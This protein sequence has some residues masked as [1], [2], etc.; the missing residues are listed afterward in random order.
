MTTPA[1]KYLPEIP[2][3]NASGAIREIYSELRRLGAVPMAALIF[4]H[5]AT[6]PGSLEWVWAAIGPEFRSG[7]LQEQAWR[8]ARE[9][10]LQPLVPIP[11]EVLA[12]LQVDV[13][14]LREV[15]DVIEAYNRA[16]PANLLAVT[17]LLRLLD[18]ARASE[19]RPGRTWEPPKSVESLTPM[20]DITTMPPE[21]ARLFALLSRRSGEVD[22][23][24][25]PSLYRH[26]GHRPQFL[27]LLITLILPRFDDGSI[28][29]AVTGIRASMDNAADELVKGMSAPPAPDPGIGAALRRFSPV[30]PR[31]I[32]VGK[33]LERSLPE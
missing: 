31:M 21:L 23:S 27:A 11:L 29:R 14:G 5:L 9:A 18:G 20:I 13:R 4:R 30:I 22:A 10:P 2:E 3:A 26:F 8:I 19:T 1:E 16:N 33:L 25:V 24:V 12:A 7:R 28:A 6:M 15:R 17:C 32:V